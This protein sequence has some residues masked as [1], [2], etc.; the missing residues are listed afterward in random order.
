MIVSLSVVRYRRIL[1]PFALL[2]MAIHRIPLALNRK[3]SF[4]KLMGCGKNGTFD[5]NPDW[6]QWALLATWDNQEDFDSFNNHSFIQSWWN[7]FAVERWTILCEPLSSHGKWDGKEPF[8]STNSG[9]DFSGPIAVLTRATIRL[10]KLKG[11]W[12]NVSP[13]ANLMQGSPGYITSIGIGEAPLFMQAT[14]S[15]W[16]S[17]ESMKSFAYDSK[18][19]I[20]VIRKT[21]TEQWYSEEL[22]ARFKILSS[23]GTL[24]DKNPLE[25]LP[26]HHIS[27]SKE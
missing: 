5:L 17:T 13:V 18:E 22:F 10:S 6:Q 25:R 9:K 7:L 24:C 3:C 4:W 19:H 27:T 2:A 20:E 26:N 16:D 8:I 11:F 1:I 14:F 23:W 12:N 21:R 15:I